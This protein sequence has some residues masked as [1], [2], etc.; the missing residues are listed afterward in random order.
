M[1]QAETQVPLGVR[2]RLGHAAAQHVAD[3][4]GARILHLK[5]YALDDSLRWPGRVG[6]DV[7]VLV[8]PADVDAFLAG[9]GE[10]GWR[11]Q[12]GFDWGSAFGH[13]ATLVHQDWGYVDVHRLFP[14]LGPD[15]VRSFETLWARRCARVL[16]GVPCA[17][18][19]LDGQILV[20][21]LHAGRDRGS[22]K[23]E[24]DV[25]SAWGDASP[26]RRASVGALVRLLGAEVGFAAAVGQL[27]DYRDHPEYRLWQVSSR[28]GTRVEEWAARVAAAPTLRAKARVVAQAPLVN[29]D[30]L[31]AQLGR[32]PTRAEIARE[33][34][35]RPVRGVREEIRRRRGA[36]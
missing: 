2:V 3:A 24:Q 14:G 30:H 23:A 13:S 7:D 18:P 11:V 29:V 19:D 27:D 25:R 8:H 26:E 16:G 22:I 1:T 4:A 31:A 21:L 15:A 12:T 36:R 9:L 17:V 10:A 6:T 34:V 33:F 35:A 32:R 5:G 20:L 28:G